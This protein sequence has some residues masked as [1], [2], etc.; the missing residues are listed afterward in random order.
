[1]KKGAGRLSSR[2]AAEDGD[3]A[4]AETGGNGD[5]NRLDQVRGE[6]RIRKE[7]AK[8]HAARGDEHYERNEYAEGAEEYRQALDL[9]PSLD[10]VR[11]KHNTALLMTGERSGTVKSLGQ[12]LSDEQ[13]VGRQ[14]QIG[15]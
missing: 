5:D 13:A 2:E 8:Y 3:A 9:D 12:S 10:D 15:R 1:P 4:A 11:E 14:Q 7:E 6:K